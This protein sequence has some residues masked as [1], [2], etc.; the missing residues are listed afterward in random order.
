MKKYLV[1]SL[2]VLPILLSGCAGSLINPQYVKTQQ[3]INPNGKKETVKTN[4]IAGHA[5]WYYWFIPPLASY[6]IATSGKCSD[7][8]YI[9]KK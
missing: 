2:F 8:S 1:L 7:K 5:A 4:C 9:I 3:I 6:K